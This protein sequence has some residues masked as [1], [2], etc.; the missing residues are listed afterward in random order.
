MNEAIVLGGS[1][2]IGVAISKQLLI[3]P[4]LRVQVALKSEKQSC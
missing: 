2:G 4:I 3:F 1:N